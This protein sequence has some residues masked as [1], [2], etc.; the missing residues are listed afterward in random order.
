[1][2]FLSLI[3]QNVFDYITILQIKFIPL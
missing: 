3:V 2:G 1:M